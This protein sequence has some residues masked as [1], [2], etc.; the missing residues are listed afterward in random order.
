M[1]KKSISLLMIGLLLVCLVGCS[2]NDNFP[3]DL[4]NAISKPINKPIKM[5]M[6]GNVIDELNNTIDLSVCNVSFSDAYSYTFVENTSDYTSG[7]LN[8]EDLQIYT[9]NN[10]DVVLDISVMRGVDNVPLYKEYLRELRDKFSNFEYNTK[11]VIFDGYD[12]TVYKFFG[13]SKQVIVVDLETDIL[14]IN[15]VCENKV[16]Q[17]DVDSIINSIHITKELLA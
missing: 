12:A 17:S 1:W 9:V 2:V 3:T 5:Q 10:N 4:N 16:N 8:I 15:S 13:G 11:E 7:M 14:V 6:G